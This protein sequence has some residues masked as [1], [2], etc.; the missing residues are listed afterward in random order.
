MSNESTFTNNDHDKKI[1][2]DI[3]QYQ[4]KDVI[5]KAE[6]KVKTSL[7]FNILL[8]LLLILCIIIFL[9]VYSEHHNVY[10]RS[11][12]SYYNIL[13]A[14]VYV[15]FRGDLPF[16]SGSF[17]IVSLLPLLLGITM[18]IL[19]ISIKFIIKGCS[20]QLCKDGLNGNRKY[21]F[22]NKELKLPVEKVDNISIEKSFINELFDGKT[23][24]IRS[25]S[26]AIRFMCVQNASEFVDKVKA[27]KESNQP[28]DVNIQTNTSNDNL[29]QI[30]KLKEMLD[31]GIITQDEF[32]AKKKQLLGL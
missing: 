19:K 9:P 31:S 2:K 24:V 27:Y 21:L 10:P 23:I 13:G 30:K 6:M 5:C 32:D 22:S 17:P 12:D 4:H 28:D 11:F 29:E 26:D 25:A 14:S 20:L 18:L 7:I 3:E 8:Y 15:K 1:V 16:I